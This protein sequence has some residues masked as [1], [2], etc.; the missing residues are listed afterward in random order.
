MEHKEDGA[1]GG[2]CDGEIRGSESQWP[3]LLQLSGFLIARWRRNQRGEREAAAAYYVCVSM[4]C[5][6]T[7]TERGE[8]REQVRML[9]PTEREKGE[10]ERWREFR[11]FRFIWLADVTNRINQDKFA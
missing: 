2:S 7:E 3:V 8:S 9:L 5:K 1:A 4:Q 10:R 11:S 6:D